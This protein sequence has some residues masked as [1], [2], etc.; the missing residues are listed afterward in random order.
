MTAAG[1]AGIND[2]AQHT[3]NSFAYTLLIIQVSPLRSRAPVIDSRMSLTA[4]WVAQFLQTRSPPVLPSIQK[5]PLAYNGK[6]LTL[7]A[8]VA[9]IGRLEVR[10]IGADSDTR[11]DSEPARSIFWPIRSENIPVCRIKKRVNGLSAA[12]DCFLMLP[13]GPGFGPAGLW[14]S[15][16][17]HG[18]GAAG[19]IHILVGEGI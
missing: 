4:R 13:Q 7:P 1:I 8:A 18:L 10:Y 2:A 5:E 6:V 19:A 11:Q 17:V 15:E 3:L 9:R 14:C 12:C 16:S